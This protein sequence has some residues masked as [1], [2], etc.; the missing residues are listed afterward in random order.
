MQLGKYFG[1][2]LKR[3]FSGM[4]LSRVSGLGRDLVMAYA[5]G[6]HA[7]V[8]A[9][10]VAFRFA[11]VLR[12][13]FGEGPLQSAFIPQFE[14]IRQENREEATVF[15]QKLSVLIG[16]LVLAIIL[17]VEGGLWVWGHSEI[18][19]LTGWMLPSLLFI[20]L[21]GLNVSFLQCHNRFFVSSMAP[22]LCNVMWMAG[23]LSLR[24]AEIHEAMA[25]LA[26]WVLGGFV[27][28]W[29]ATA[30]QLRGDLTWKGWFQGSL[31]HRGVKELAKAFSL[32]ALGVGA[33]QINAFFDAIFARVAHPSGPVYLWYANRF[34][35]L[36]LAIFGIAAVN[37]LVPVLSRAIK[38]GEHEKGREIFSFGCRRVLMLMIPMTFAI[39][40]LGLSAID[41]VFGHGSF[42]AHAT[43]QT[44]WCLSAYAL[45]LVPSTLVMYYA[46]V[47]YAQGNFRTATLFSLLTVGVNLGLN[48][49][50][51]FAW[52]WGPISTALATSIGAWCNFLGLRSRLKGWKMG[53]TFRELGGVVLG[54]GIAS[55][56]AFTLQGH[57][58]HKILEFG[59]PGAVFVA[60]ILLLFGKRLFDD[61]AAE[62]N[63]VVVE[64]H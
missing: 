30:W 54:S 41:L 20:S 61:R 33:V 40:V 19:H 18:L 14:G 55:G 5:F 47:F 15:F 43:E 35:Q 22:F 42:S 59:V 37:T 51:I 23:A 27:I 12:R 29:V 13:F 21:Y 50:F 52:G 3:F 64:D 11:N 56:A 36:A 31:L 2:G 1:S 46:A 57:L 58:G 60:V 32:G 17:G 45:G 39:C 8:G 48:S 26:K 6:D 10:I 25:G 49:L 28:Q 53:M 4:M 24:H 7:A 9:F 38:G 63:R 34:Q 16:G 44:A 62:T